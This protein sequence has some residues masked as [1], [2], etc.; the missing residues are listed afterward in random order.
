MKNKTMKSQG[1]ETTRSPNTVK[2]LMFDVSLPTASFLY[3]AFNVLLFIGAFAVAV[4]TYGSIKMGA[5]KEHFADERIATNEAATTRAMAD[6]EIAK[7]G[8]AEAHERA[9]QLEK[10]AA[11]FE[12]RLLAERRLTAL[13]RWRLARLER[14]VLPRALTKEQH[15]RMVDALRGK[16]SELTIGVVQQ[17]EPMQFGKTLLAVLEDA[18]AAVKLVVLPATGF[19]QRGVSMV[20]ANDEGKMIAQVLWNEAG[21]VGGYSTSTPMGLESIVLPGL[22]VLIVGENDAASRP[23]AGQPGEGMDTMGRPIPMPQ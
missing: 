1:A 22:N 3:D 10:D 6:S 9:A 16:V 17:S 8:A 21:I 15:D 23:G 5:I 20:V 18:G 4:G 7:K 11:S 14:A 12:E 13:E 2:V 19:E